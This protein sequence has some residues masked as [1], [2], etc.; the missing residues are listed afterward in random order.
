MTIESSGYF[1]MHVAET[2]KEYPSMMCPILIARHVLERIGIS[3]LSDAEFAQFTQDLK[4][5]DLQ[6]KH[7]DEYEE[8]EIA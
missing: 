1:G 6:T 8:R 3:T 4:H 2:K 5:Y 7:A